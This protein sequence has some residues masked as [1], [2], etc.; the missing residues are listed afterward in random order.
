VPATPGS[1]LKRR[2]EKEIEE[3]GM[4]IKVTEQSGIPFKCYLQRSNPFKSKKCKRDDCLVC[5]PGGKGTC[6]ATGVTYEIVCKECNC[7]YVGEKIYY[8][9][10]LSIY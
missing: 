8:S 7:K 4:K 9:Y 1:E 5:I 2:Y 6:Y 3:A 10:K